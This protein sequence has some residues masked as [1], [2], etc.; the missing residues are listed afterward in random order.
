MERAITLSRRARSLSAKG[1]EA[2][3]LTLVGKRQ[4]SFTLVIRLH[5]LATANEVRYDRSHVRSGGPQRLFNELGE[6]YQ[7]RPGGY[8]A[9]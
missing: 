1:S 4:G 9:F 6:R 5:R 7:D 2:R 3:A 8:T